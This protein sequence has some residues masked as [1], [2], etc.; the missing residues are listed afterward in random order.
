MR[1]RIALAAVLTALALATCACAPA[2]L[3]SDAA[4]EIALP[5]PSPEAQNMI[6]GE[7]IATRLVDVALYFPAS[8]GAGFSSVTRSIRAESGEELIE[9]AINALLSTQPGSESMALPTGDTRLLSCEFACGVATINLSLDARNVQSPQELL[10]LETA[11]GNT[12][13]GIEGVTG[14]NVLISGQSESFWQLPVGVQTETVASVTASYAQLQAERDRLMVEDAMPVSRKALAYFP[15]DDSSWLVPELRD[16][17]FRTSDYASALIELLQTGPLDRTCAVS[18]IPEGVEL[19]DGGP[20]TETLPTGERVLTIHFSS[21]LANYLAFSGLEVWELLGSVALTTCSFLPEIDAVRI[22]VGGEPITICEMGDAILSFPDGLI[23]R[24]DFSSRIGSIVT[25]YL[26]NGDGG[27]QRVSRAV[28][29]HSAY[30]PRSLLTN[31][32]SYAG[33]GGGLRFP[34]PQSVYP[35]DLLGVQVSDGIAQINLSA[36]F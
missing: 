24:S 31:L 34:G 6:L 21:A 8:D 5:E 4:S 15:T 3:D 12:L 22:L 30:S 27:L 11:I 14:V 2:G 25:L 23:R 9:A 7:Q 32:F 26:A 36:E 29:T 28:S 13:L 35:E 33:E 16:V 19:M 1:R 18:S 20:V 17:V 10:A